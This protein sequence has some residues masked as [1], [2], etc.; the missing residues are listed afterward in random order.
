MKSYFP[1]PH[2]AIRAVRRVGGTTTLWDYVLG[3]RSGTTFWSLQKTKRKGEE[4]TGK[5]EKGGKAKRRCERNGLFILSSQKEKRGNKMNV[6][7]G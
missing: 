3:L 4:R 6:V 7:Q 1:Q 2:L 5:C